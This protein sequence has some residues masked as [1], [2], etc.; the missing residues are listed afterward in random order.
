[1]NREQ[2]ET[3]RRLAREVYTACDAALDAI[4]LEAEAL[5]DFLERDYCERPGDKSSGSKATGALR[6]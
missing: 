6:C 2:I 3:V 5:S 1:M 4:N